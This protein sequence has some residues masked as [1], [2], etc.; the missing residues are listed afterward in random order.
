MQSTCPTLSA[1]GAST[2]DGGGLAS[3]PSP[4]HV[5]ALTFPGSLPGEGGRLAPPPPPRHGLALTSPGSRRGEGGRRAGGGVVVPP[6][7]PLQ[8]P[9]PRPS[10]TARRWLHSGHIVGE[11]ETTRHRFPTNCRMHPS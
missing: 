9:S 4:R 2:D 6:P 1:G 5:L 3:R 10:P 7:P 8:R 11:G